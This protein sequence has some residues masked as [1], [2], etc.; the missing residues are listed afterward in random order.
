MLREGYSLDFDMGELT[1]EKD[2]IVA[3]RGFSVIAG[4]GYD[5]TIMKHAEKLKE[6]FG[7]GAYVAAALTNPMPKQAHFTLHLDEEIIEADGIAVLLLNFAKIYPDISITHNNDARD[8]LLEIAV[9]KPQ[10]TVELLPALFAAYL[11]RSGGF[12]HRAGA[13]EMFKAKSIRIESDPILDLQYDGETPECSTPLS[14]RVLVGATRLIVTKKEY[15][16]LTE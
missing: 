16:R 10:N 9:L 8:G 1:F 14:A 6:A 11:D 2:G 7:P 5:A 13:I 4:A 12:P 15:D 3:T